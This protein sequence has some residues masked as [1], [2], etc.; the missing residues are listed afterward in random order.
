MKNIILISGKLQS[1][2]NQLSD[3]IQEELKNNYKNLKVQTDLFAKDLKDWCKEDFK[4]LSVVLKNIGKEIKSNV[5][6]LFDNP[7]KFTN[8]S[9]E[10]MIKAIHKSV[11]KLNITDGNW[12]E[13]KTDITRVIL[14]LYGT[15]IFRKRVDDNWWSK[16]LA[17]RCISSEADVI[18][19]TDT[20]FPNE[21]EVFNQYINDEVNVS[22]VRIERNIKTKSHITNH[23]SE[24]ALDNWLEWTY[25]IDNNKSLDDLKASAKLIIDDILNPSDEIK[26]LNIQELLKK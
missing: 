4:K 5:N 23:D 13:N 7:G 10:S 18:I 15:E 19:I 3:F 9:F 25:I 12:Y 1:G 14:Q 16:K 22:T 20:R 11:D 8:N 6:V 21:I 2:K 26:E 17:E 24:I